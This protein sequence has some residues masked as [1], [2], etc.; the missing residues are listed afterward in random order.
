MEAFSALL[1]ICGEFPSQRACYDDFDISWMWDRI[2]YQTVERTVIWDCI[3]FL[4][5]HCN[6]IILRNR[7]VRVALV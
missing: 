1:A 4:G 5:R 3:M 7:D 6:E 2:M